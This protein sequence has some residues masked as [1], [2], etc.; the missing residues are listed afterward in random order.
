MRMKKRLGKQ[1]SVTHEQ[2]YQLF[3]ILVFL[4][5]AYIMY[6]FVND[7]NNSTIFEKNYIARDIAMV[8]NTLY[9]SPGYVSYDYPENI[10]R[11]QI[12][13]KSNKVRIKDTGKEGE[14]IEKR[15]ASP[16]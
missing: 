12:N 13:I 3:E 7:V 4:F 15:G 5:Y 11:Y 10:S 2:L 9:A 1:G 14:D 6:S 8:T 16:S